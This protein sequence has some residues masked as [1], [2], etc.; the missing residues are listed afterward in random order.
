MAWS[1]YHSNNGEWY[2]FFLALLG[3]FE[4]FDERL[5]LMGGGG[6]GHP[7]IIYLFVNLGC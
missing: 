3:L 4:V 6:G 1:P 7:W 2:L 5:S